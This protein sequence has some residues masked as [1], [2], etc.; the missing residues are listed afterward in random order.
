MKIRHL[1]ILLTVVAVISC[2]SDKKKTNERN[3]NKLVGTWRLIE[4]SDYDTVTNKWTHPYGDHPK[5]YFTYTNSG[6][7]NLN[8][9]AEKPLLSCF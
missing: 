2:N 8:G 6:I 1:I 5:G 4:Y 7:V 9:S 3:K